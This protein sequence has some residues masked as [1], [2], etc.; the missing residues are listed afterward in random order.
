MAKTTPT[1]GLTQ[2]DMEGLEV[3]AD[4]IEINLIG[5]LDNSTPFHLV[6]QDRF[7][8]GFIIVI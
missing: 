7:G 1:S 4:N 5:N 8:S 6:N 2:A 3:I